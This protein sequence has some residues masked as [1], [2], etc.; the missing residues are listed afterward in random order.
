MYNQ[1]VLSKRQ[2]QFDAIAHYA[3]GHTYTRT[4]VFLPGFSGERANLKEVSKLLQTKSLKKGVLLFV[5][6]AVNY[7]NF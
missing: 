7:K 1:Y 4:A 3:A 2:T 5:V 6:S